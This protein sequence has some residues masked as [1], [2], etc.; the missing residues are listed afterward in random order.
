METNT[1]PKPPTGTFDAP[2][3]TSQGTVSPEVLVDRS[4]GGFQLYTFIGYI[5]LVLGFVI[6]ASDIFQTYRVFTKQARPPQLFTFEGIKLDLAKL[7]PSLPMS[8]SIKKLMKDS[9]ISLPQVGNTAS[10][11]TEILPP[12]M[13][14]DASNLGAFMFLVGFF[15]NV[16][17]KIANI[18]VK[19]IRPVYIKA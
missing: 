7:T 10:E 5:C 8:D 18:G 11:L 17:Y 19:L 9:N 12:E 4:A 1:I 16:G 13:I 3:I 6:I 14:N 2:H 15:L